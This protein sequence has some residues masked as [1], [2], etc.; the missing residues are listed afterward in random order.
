MMLSPILAKS[1]KNGALHLALP[2]RKF[3]RGCSG[4]KAGIKMLRE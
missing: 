3:F 2:E 4:I 1:F